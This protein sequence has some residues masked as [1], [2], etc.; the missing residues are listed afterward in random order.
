MTQNDI[1][2]L[3]KKLGC[4][5]EEAKEILAEDERI[6]KMTVAEAQ[7][8]LTSE[9]KKAIK[10]ASATGSR[11]RTPVKRERKIDSRK[12]F[13]IDKIYNCLNGCLL[14]DKP[15]KVNETEIHFTY[16]GEKYTVKLIKHRPQK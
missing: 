4:T 16:I 1:S 5:P 13:F 3:V 9:Q 11:K 12:K 15:E 14:D 6:D 10:T 8:D 7:A 2:L